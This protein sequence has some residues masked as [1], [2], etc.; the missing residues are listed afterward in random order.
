MKAQHESQYTHFAFNRLA[1]NP[2]YAGSKDDLTVGGLYRHQWAGIDGAPRT[3]NAFVHTPFFNGKCGA[4][5]SLYADKIGVT[6]TY[7]GALDY[8]YKIKMAGGTLSLGL[9]GEMEYG[10]FDLS[11]ANPS[12]AI[13]NV[14]S[15]TASSAT[16]LAPNFGAGAYFATKRYYVGF[17]VPRLLKSHLYQ[18]NPKGK[19]VRNM[20]LT[21]GAV[22]PVGTNVKLV[23]S[24]MLTFN[25]SAPLVV[26]LNANLVFMNT[27][28]VGASLRPGDSIDGM[29]QYQ[30][31]GQTRLG[32]SY[33][34]TTSALRK[35][36]KC[37][38]EI[39]FEHTFCNC[40]KDNITNLRFF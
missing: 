20:F 22:L 14:I 10:N 3:M 17:S 35:S 38:F 4:G 31:S 19:S 26:D 9:R 13:D 21:G 6:Q 32:M 8:S 16:R 24:A 1:Y 2:G 11:N 5:L 23:P 37:S 18:L 25:P 12:D 33:D 39:M 30:L 28:W 40:A 7:S 15:T 27:L 34:F 29:I 36:S